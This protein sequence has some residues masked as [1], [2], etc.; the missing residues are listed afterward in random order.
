[1]YVL[2]KTVPAVERGGAITKWRSS[3]GAKAGR[4]QL[5]GYNPNGQIGGDII[6]AL[7]GDG[8]FI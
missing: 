4:F 7:E 2:T 6:A 8:Q 3:T 1:M 5:H